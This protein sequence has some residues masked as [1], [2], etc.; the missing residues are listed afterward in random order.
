MES[1]WGYSTQTYWVN[2]Q[3][4]ISVT[5]GE[6]AQCRSSGHQVMDEQASTFPEDAVSVILNQG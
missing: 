3:V 1:L 2:E 6:A 4:K 5:V